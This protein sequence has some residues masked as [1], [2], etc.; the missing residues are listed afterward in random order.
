MKIAYARVEGSDAAEKKAHLLTLRTKRRNRSGKNKRHVSKSR[1]PPQTAKRQKS[2]ETKSPPSNA[3][4]CEED[5]NPKGKDKDKAIYDGYTVVNADD[6]T[7]I[8]SSYH[9]CLCNIGALPL[10]KILKAWIKVIQPKKQRTYPY[11]G[12][13]HTAPYWW[14]PTTNDPKSDCRHIEPDHL[15]R[16]G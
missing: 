9:F 1:R 7:T 4:W 14:P 15:H 3:P 10:K 13:E 11:K 8:I 2:S 6:K 16:N 5:E 12:R